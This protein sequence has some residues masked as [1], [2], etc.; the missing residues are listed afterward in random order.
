MTPAGLISDS[1]IKQREECEPNLSRG[2]ASFGKPSLD[3]P[4]VHIYNAGP[5]FCH[6]TMCNAPRLQIHRSM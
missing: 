2:V 1:S 6:V 4:N 3:H 5:S